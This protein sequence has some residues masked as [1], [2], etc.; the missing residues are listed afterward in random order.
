[1]TYQ[2]VCIGNENSFVVNKLN[3][4]KRGIVNQM[5]TVFQSE[6]NCSKQSPDVGR[7]MIIED[8]GDARVDEKAIEGLIFRKDEERSREGQPEEQ[9][10]S[11][12]VVLPL[13]LL[14]PKNS[15]YQ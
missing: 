15:Q 1:M 4:T 12:T 6:G 2:K 7:L 8:T 5:P 9:Q 13:R 11:H 14:K 3:G 10:K